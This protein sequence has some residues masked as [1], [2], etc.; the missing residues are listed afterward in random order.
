MLKK[1]KWFTLTAVVL[2]LIIP[3]LVFGEGN[4]SPG[5]G[6]GGSEDG[7]KLTIDKVNDE[8]NK[9][10]L[11]LGEKTSAG[12]GVLI[13]GI[14]FVKNEAVIRYRVITPADDHLTA[15]VITEPKAVT[16]IASKYTPKLRAAAS[17]DRPRTAPSKPGK[18]GPSDNIVS[19]PI[20]SG[21]IT[22]IEEISVTVPPKAANPDAPVNS[23]DQVQPG[24]GKRKIVQFTLEVQDG[25]GLGAD[26]AVVRI[27]DATEIYTKKG[28]ELVAATVQNL[29]TGTKVEVTFDGPVQES[30]P[31]KGTA[32]KIVI[33]Q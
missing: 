33:L 17:D 32:G 7:V 26:K 23:S 20:V 21:K 4:Q 18:G 31:V 27:T 25:S 6:P 24:S 19:E 12:Y 8:V 29:K 1:W 9:V 15:A 3:G 14:D 10:T 2:M 16:Y 11:S 5:R 13:E 22:Q 28:S 30:Y